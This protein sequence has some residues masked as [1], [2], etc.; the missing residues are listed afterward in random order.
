MPFMLFAKT[1][2]KDLSDFELIEAYRKSM[3][4]RYLNELFSRYAYLVL[5]VCNKYFSNPED[6]R[7]ATMEVLEKLAQGIV[8]SDVKNFKSWLYVVT[9]NLCL[10]KLQKSKDLDF[11]FVPIDGDETNYFMYFSEI[12]S[13]IDEDDDHSLKMKQAL[14]E[15]IET[16]DPHQRE[17]L[18][19][20]YYEKKS[21][22]E[23]MEMKNW[24]KDQVRSYLQNGRRNIKIYLKK[25]GLY[26]ENIEN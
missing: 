14:K 5:F 19:L 25:S 3:N 20:F 23:I 21:Y 9:K 1:R 22:N 12:D 16:L 10:N 24:D 8:K 4:D 17:C 18:M 7:D 11:Q 26:V 13:L 2:Y 6:S 15:A